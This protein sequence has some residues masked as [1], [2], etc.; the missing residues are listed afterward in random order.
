MVQALTS[1]LCAPNVYFAILLGYYRRHEK[2]GLAFWHP[3]CVDY[4]AL[5]G[6]RSKSCILPEP[7]FSPSW[8]LFFFHKAPCRSCDVPAEYFVVT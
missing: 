2:Y 5:P 6:I 3:E 4:C 1:T 7:R 8:C